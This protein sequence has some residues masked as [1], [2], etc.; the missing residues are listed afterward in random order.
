MAKTSTKRQDIS[1]KEQAEAFLQLTPEKQ[2][3]ELGNLPYAVQVK[4]RESIES[5]RGVRHVN[6]RLEFSKTEL[7]AQI[8]RLKEKRD[9]YAEREVVLNERIAELEEELSNRE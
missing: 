7:K 6:G 2:A 5:E 8:A 9:S 4:V 1:V 3:K